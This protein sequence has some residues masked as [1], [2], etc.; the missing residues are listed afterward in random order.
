MSIVHYAF[1]ILRM[2]RN[3]VNEVANMV[4]PPQ[5]L[6]SEEPVSAVGVIEGALW[7][8]I[9]FLA[10]PACARC[11]MPLPDAFHD[12]TICLA[13]LANPPAFNTARAAFAYDDVSRGLV[14]ALKR[15]GRADGIR[16][17]SLWMS[18]ANTALAQSDLILPVPL[19]WSRL[20]QRGFNQSGWLAA[21]VSKRLGVPWHPGILVRKKPSKSQAGLSSS[22]R[23]RNV[24][25]A[26]GVTALRKRRIVGKR[27]VL[28]DD[29]FTTGATVE[30]CTKVLLRAG[31]AQIDVLCLARVVKPVRIDMPRL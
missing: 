27:I 31:A 10:G 24:Q 30:A 17:F 13:C 21:A 3:V 29:V 4:W 5:S 1:V 12:E 22:E 14:L 2:T 28:I 25:G 26:F 16:V 23:L 19:H 9:D 8:A 18:Q 11:G 6:L 15:G 7:Q 20:W